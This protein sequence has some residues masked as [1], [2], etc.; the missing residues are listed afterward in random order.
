[1]ITDEDRSQI[2]GPQKLWD[3][4][5]RY[6]MNIREKEGKINITGLY[7][8]GKDSHSKYGKESQDWKMESKVRDR[9][10]LC[11]LR[12]TRICTLL[13]LPLNQVIKM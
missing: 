9:G 5:H 1:M 13:M 6:R 11:N 3:E 12:R 8:D 2:I 7:F 10:S 4:R